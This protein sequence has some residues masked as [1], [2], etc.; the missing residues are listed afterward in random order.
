MK[1]VAFL[2]LGLLVGAG[3]SFAQPGSPIRFEPKLSAG[4]PPPTLYRKQRP[5]P[6]KSAS[7]TTLKHAPTGSSASETEIICGMKVI[8]KGPE[9][10]PGIIVTQKHSDGL[11]VRRIQPQFCGER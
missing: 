9:Q 7:R 4:A 11:A 3:Q 8:R 2:C 5:A 6:V 1:L 10:D